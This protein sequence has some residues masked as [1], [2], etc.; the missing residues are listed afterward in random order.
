MS[1]MDAET[2]NLFKELHSG[3]L[4]ASKRGNVRAARELFEMADELAV[5]HK[6]DRA[7]LDALNPLA[8]AL[9]SINDFYGATDKL[10]T[11]TE[12]ASELNLPDEEAIAISNLGRMA[13]VRVVRLYPVDDITEA[14]ADEAVPRFTLAREKLEGHAH[15]YYRYANACHGAPIAAIAGNETEAS[16]LIAE[17]THVARRRSPE[18]YDQ[19]VTHTINPYGLHQIAL[20]SMYLAHH[21]EDELLLK[22]IIDQIH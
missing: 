13:A 15:Y 8:R 20:A 6:D 7:R 19:V 12:I 11:A 1:G 3:G 17:G 5:M 14:L 4:Q 9:W 2:G 18:P 21:C 16:N 10:V 22:Q